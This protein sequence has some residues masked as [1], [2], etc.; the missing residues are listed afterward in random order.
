MILG[1]AQGL[2]LEIL[3]SERASVVVLLSIVLFLEVCFAS[4]CISNM[5]VRMLLDR[6]LHGWE[7][8]IRSFE[9]ILA[10]SIKNGLRIVLTC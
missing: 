3:D 8:K 4:I 9:L 10:S 6:L 2:L 7:E 5:K 1:I